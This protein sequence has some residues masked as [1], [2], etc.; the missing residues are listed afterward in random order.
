VCCVFVVVA[1]FACFAVLETK[2]RAL[3]ML[4]NGSTTELHPYHC[5]N[6]LKQGLITTDQSILA[7]S[8]LS[9]T[10]VAKTGLSEGF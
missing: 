8:P 1:V 4:G 3:H 2:P 5:V 6:L 9:A 7:P 10:Q